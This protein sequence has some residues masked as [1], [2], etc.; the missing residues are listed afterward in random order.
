M[1]ILV[2]DNNINA[3]LRVLKKKMFNNGVIQEM[4]QRKFYEKPTD[5]RR[6]LKK[7]GIRRAKIE[8]NKRR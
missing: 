4:N 2:R 3:A 7:E 6:R 5:K 8:E 1:Q